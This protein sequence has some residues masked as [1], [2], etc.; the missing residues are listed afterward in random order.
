MNSLEIVYSRNVVEFVTVAN[1]YCQAIEQVNRINA[2]ANL[3]KM[4][5]LNL[6]VLLKAPNLN[7]FSYYLLIKWVL[8]LKYNNL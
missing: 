1:E 5:K 4:Q 2:S 3:Q 8:K 6:E 7:D